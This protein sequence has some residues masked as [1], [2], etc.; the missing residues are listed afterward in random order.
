VTF[1]QQLTRIGR[2]ETTQQFARLLGWSTFAF[3]IERLGFT[4]AAYICATV[5]DPESFGR[6]SFAQSIVLGMQTFAI[7]GGTGLI[8][9]YVPEF[10]ALDKRRD[11]A[12]ILRLTVV[13]LAIASAA[14][15][16]LL[17]A[18]SKTV[19]TEFLHD[20]ADRLAP[21]LLAIWLIISSF[22]ALLQSTALALQ[23]GRT[24]AISGTLGGLLAAI[25]IPTGAVL[26][27]Y[28][29]MM[30]SAIAVELL[31][32]IV[33]SRPLLKELRSYAEP[34]FGPVASGHWALLVRYGLPV[35][36]QGIMYAPV[37]AAG[38][39]LFLHNAHEGLRHLGAY[40]YGM[41]YFSVALA[42]SS[43]TN[44]VSMPL[45]SRLGAAS[46][47]RRFVAT[48]NNLS[49]LQLVLAALL[50][51]LLFV[52][53]IRIA[54]GH[55]SEARPLVALLLVASVL[56]AAQNLLMNALFVIERQMFVLLSAVLWAA[57]YIFLVWRLSPIG[58]YG[59]CD[60]L[61][62]ANLARTLLLLGAWL[63]SMPRLLAPA[64]V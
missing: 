21:V 42:A 28:K 37:L 62:I 59:L 60:A 15:G 19:S 58:A 3:G 38:Q 55:Y 23:N 41:I 26:Y 52:V 8:A 11:V 14:L 20:D 45:L 53:A 44:R 4:F 9:R 46:D 1:A 48:V 57:F 5:L 24:L 40:N 10:R 51:L 43:Q 54:P 13:V 29:G 17:L 31:K 64:L 61:M 49:L 16:S 2:S 30:L 47:W 25:A 27:G 32:G 34:I 56:T 22:A 18:F 39:A 7:A 36:L 33:L 35:F 12:S 63:T 6:W 50:S